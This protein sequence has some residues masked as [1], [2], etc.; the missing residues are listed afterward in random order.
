MPNNDPDYVICNCCGYWMAFGGWDISC[1]QCG[2]NDWKPADLHQLFAPE[3][4]YL[5][6]LFA[7]HARCNKDTR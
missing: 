3:H 1:D 5:H 7:Q 2:E 4:S 6:Q